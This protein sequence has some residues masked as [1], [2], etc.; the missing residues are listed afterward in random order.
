MHGGDQLPGPERFSQADGRAGFHGQRK[1]IQ[2]GIHRF[3][4]DE[5]R[6]RKDRHRRSSSAKLGN[7]LKPADIG[8]KNIDDRQIK[9]RRFKCSHPDTGVGHM[10]S[11]TTFA[12]QRHHNRRANRWIVFNNQDPRHAPP[13]VPSDP[14]STNIFFKIGPLGL[15]RS[16]AT[17]ITGDFRL[18]QL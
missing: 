2:N 10:D 11:F 9:T 15:G 14:A 1:I 12:T 17:P 7:G 4:E 13:A 8:Q 3:A 18:Y 16:T 5:T 6:N